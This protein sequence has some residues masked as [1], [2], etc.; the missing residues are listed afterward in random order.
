MRSRL[1]NVKCHCLHVS[2]LDMCFHITH[3]KDC[4]DARLTAIKESVLYVCT[5][6]S[7][8]DALALPSA[9]IRGATAAIYVSAVPPR[10]SL[11]VG[12]V[13]I[14]KAD[15]ATNAIAHPRKDCPSFLCAHT[16]TPTKTKRHQVNNPTGQEE[17][18][19]SGWMRARLI[20]SL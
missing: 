3:H 6:K 14:I 4:I 11:V 7:P 2:Y 19:A 5:R 9:P 18:C 10:V 17:R 1:A 13:T 15:I 16:H 20:V 12:V 8:S